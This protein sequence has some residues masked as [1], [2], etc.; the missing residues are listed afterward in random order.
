MVAITLRLS[1]LSHTENVY[2]VPGLV[3]F[4]KS[5]KLVKRARRG[6]AWREQ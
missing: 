6:G 3:S 2:N 5:G 4:G 1:A